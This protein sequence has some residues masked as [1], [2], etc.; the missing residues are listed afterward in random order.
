MLKCVNATMFLT[1]VIIFLQ[2]NSFKLLTIFIKKDAKVRF[3][4]V[5]CFVINRLLTGNVVCS[6]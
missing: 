5:K 1:C 3:F 4:R 6:P 2:N